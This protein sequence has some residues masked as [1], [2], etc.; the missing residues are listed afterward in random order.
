MHLEQPSMP[1]NMEQCAINCEQ[2]S[3][4]QAQCTRPSTPNFTPLTLNPYTPNPWPST[5]TPELFC[6]QACMAKAR[7]I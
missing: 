3:I 7:C 4:V 2:A 6:E 5:L 1:M